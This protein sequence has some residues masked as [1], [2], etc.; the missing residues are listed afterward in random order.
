MLHTLS[1]EIKIFSKIFINEKLELEMHFDLVCL[2]SHPLCA[3][4][5]VVEGFSYIKVQNQ[6]DT[7]CKSGCESGSGSAYGCGAS[8]QCGRTALVCCF[9]R[10]TRERCGKTSP[11]TMAR[12]HWQLH[13]KVNTMAP[14]GAKA[15]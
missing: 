14:H 7:L 11:S 2:S 9:L 8:S 4:V 5:I 12:A 15:T 3:A 13:S 6:Q 10:A 1:K